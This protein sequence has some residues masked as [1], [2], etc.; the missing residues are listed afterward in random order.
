MKQEEVN[1]ATAQPQEQQNTQQPAQQ[2]RK[3]GQYTDYESAPSNPAL[4]LFDLEVTGPKR[5][6]DRIITMSFLAYDVDGNL[7]G[8]FAPKINPCGVRINAICH[9]IHGKLASHR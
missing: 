9:R 2:Q 4:F 1:S 6:F 5:N 8:A 3:K 7:M